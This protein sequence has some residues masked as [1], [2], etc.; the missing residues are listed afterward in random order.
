MPVCSSECNF[1]SSLQENIA[2]D[3]SGN[4]MINAK[5]KGHEC[6]PIRKMDVIMNK[7]ASDST[8]DVRKVR[9]KS[10]RKNQN[11][12][13]KENITEPEVKKKMS[14]D[15][16]SSRFSKLSMNDLLHDLNRIR[17]L[18]AASDVGILGDNRNRMKR[19]DSVTMINANE[20]NRRKSTTSSMEEQNNAE[21]KSVIL[22]PEN[23]LHSP[24]DHDCTLPRGKNR[25]LVTY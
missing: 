14:M 25:Y 19:N 11:N 17:R 12:F 13:I 4:E 1:T 8:A 16:S 7:C 10:R 2:A 15:E 23:S 3:K 20:R 18:S 5:M 22:D 21:M 6:N 24:R 9:R